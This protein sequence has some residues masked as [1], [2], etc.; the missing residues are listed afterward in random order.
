MKTVITIVLVVLLG[1][2]YCDHRRDQNTLLGNYD[3]QGYDYSG[4]LIFNGSITFTSFENTELTGT[5][6]VI[7]VDSGFEGA[8]NKDGPCAGEVSGDRI[9][10]YLSP[11]LS[12]GGV[13]FEGHYTES[14]LTGTWRI[15]NVAGGKTFGTFEAIK[16]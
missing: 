13:D 4:K 12:D 9:T 15:Q 6:K 16:Q 11:T 1:M 5:C 14:R 3:L 8:V 2:G 10:L 7:K